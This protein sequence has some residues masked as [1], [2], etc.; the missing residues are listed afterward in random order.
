MFMK[1]TVKLFQLFV[2]MAGCCVRV[3]G[4]LLDLLCDCSI[5]VYC[6]KSDLLLHCPAAPDNH[7]YLYMP[8]MMHITVALLL[9]WWHHK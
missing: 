6:F 7:K 8:N 1:S 5:R 4:V 2:T 3:F 9:S